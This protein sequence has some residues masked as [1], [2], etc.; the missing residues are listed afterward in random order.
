MCGNAPTEDNQLEGQ[1]ETQRRRS[2]YRRSGT[3]PATQPHALVH[4][5]IV[6]ASH[7]ND[8]QHNA[9]WVRSTA[10]G[11]PADVEAATTSP[12]L[13]E[14]MPAQHA[15]PSPA[16]PGFLDAMM[17]LFSDP[18]PEQLPAPAAAASHA[19]PPASDDAL[20]LAALL[21]LLT[22]RCHPR[23]ESLRPARPVEPR[24]AAIVPKATRD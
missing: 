23:A 18:A 22:L 9:W 24:T 8:E 5:P 4:H 20:K 2:Q 17:S 16:S 12:Q 15:A 1:T 7:A 21:L 14:A 19:A 6:P 10:G 13:A 3:A 11:N